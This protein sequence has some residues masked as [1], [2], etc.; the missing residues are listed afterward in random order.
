MDRTR[1]KTPHT[2]SLQREAYEKLYA[3]AQTIAVIHVTF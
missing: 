3:A 2:A 1:Q